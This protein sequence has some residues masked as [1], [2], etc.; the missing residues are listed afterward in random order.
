VRIARRV[1]ALGVATDV[2]CAS[3]ILEKI[4][5]QRIALQESPAL[6]AANPQALHSGGSSSFLFA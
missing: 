3:R 5:L 2:P 1:A 4:R 6:R